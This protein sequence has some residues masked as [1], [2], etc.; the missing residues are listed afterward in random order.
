MA[1]PQPFLVRLAE[2]A[3][4][5]ASGLHIFRDSL[6]KNATRITAV[7][8]ELFA[9]STAL[10]ELGEAQA[11]PRHQPSFYRIENDVRLV[12]PSLQF[13]LD[14]AFAMFGRARSRSQQMVWDDLEHRMDV[15]ERVGFLERLGWYRTF[16]EGLFQRL[17]GER[18][19]SMGPLRMR[20][21]VLLDVQEETKLAGRRNSLP[22]SCMFFLDRRSRRT[23]WRGID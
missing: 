15:D 14:D 5:V 7:I 3:E 13:T 10:R 6:P 21:R 19:D 16:L 22:I 1:I 20:I 18:G 12:L 17:D 8:S 9:L 2:T 23:T 4:D 11:N